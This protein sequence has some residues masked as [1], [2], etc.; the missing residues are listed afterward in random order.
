MRR[1]FKARPKYDLQIVKII[2]TIILVYLLFF[3]IIRPIFRLVSNTSSQ[4]FLSLAT[5]NLLGEPPFN[6]HLSLPLNNPNQFLELTLGNI[7]IN[8]SLPNAQPVIHIPEANYPIVYIYNTHPNENFYP[9]ALAIHNI[10]PNVVMASYML[11]AALAEY[12]IV[13]IVESRDVR[14]ILRA[15]N[16]RFNQSYLASR[17][18]IQDV[19][20]RYP[21]IRYF[22][23]VH[24]DSRAGSVTIDGI[25]YARMM[26]VI[27][28]NHPNYQENK[29]LMLNI[30]QEI[31][32]NYPDLMRNPFFRPNSSFNQDLAPGVILIEV[33]DP[34]NTID[35]VYNSINV[36]ASSFARVIKEE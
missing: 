36:F 29:A 26:F 6:H 27:G 17:K 5:N 30:H 22:I 4:H 24:R 18:L 25:T 15:N 12:G 20:E 1:R 8:S 9:G 14:D 11:E 13:S 7:D 16:W 34:R 28:K 31:N 35:E 21:T 19:K 3:L 23:D 33:G 2:L 32:H 10:T